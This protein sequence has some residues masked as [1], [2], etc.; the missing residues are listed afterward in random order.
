MNKRWLIPVLI[1]AA[2]MAACGSNPTFP[3]V[4]LD[5][6][7]YREGDLPSEGMSINVRTVDDEKEWKYLQ[8]TNLKLRNADAE[9]VLDVDVILF[10]DKKELYKAYEVFTVGESQKEYAEYDPPAIGYALIGRRQ[11]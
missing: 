4:S 9:T 1:V 3:S 6:L 8:W 7:A 2:A 5:G 11:D 10:S